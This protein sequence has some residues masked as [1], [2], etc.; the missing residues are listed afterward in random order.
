MTRIFALAIVIVCTMTLSGFVIP[1]NQGIQPLEVVYSGVIGDTA[2]L[3]GL[4]DSLANNTSFTDFNGTVI[5]AQQVSTASYTLLQSINAGAA[6]PG[7]GTRARPFEGRFISGNRLNTISMGNQW[8]TGT[9]SFGLFN[10]VRG[11]AEFINITTSGAFLAEN[12]AAVGSLIGSVIGGDVRIVTTHTIMNITTDAGIAGGVIGA[13]EL[14]NVTIL[15]NTVANITVTGGTHAGAIIG[16]VG[17]V[18]A[19][20]VNIRH[21][22]GAV[23][24]GVLARYHAVN[25]AAS[26][27]V[28]E[29]AMH[30][31]FV[32]G[33]I[34]NGSEVGITGMGH[35]TN[36]TAPTALF[37]PIAGI[38]QW[39][40]VTLAGQI[41]AGSIFNAMNIAV[42]LPPNLVTPFG[43]PFHTGPGTLSWVNVSTGARNIT[44]N[45]IGLGSILPYFN[46]RLP[47]DIQV[48]AN[49][50]RLVHNFANLNTAFIEMRNPSPS[51]L[52][53]YRDLWALETGVS[54]NGTVI[55]RLS[56]N[57]YVRRVL[58]IGLN[59]L[60]AT[61]SAHDLI[62]FDVDGY[63]LVNLHNHFNVLPHPFSGRE[64]FLFEVRTAAGGKVEEVPV[65]ISNVANATVNMRAGEFTI[66]VFIFVPD[67][68]GLHVGNTPIEDYYLFATGTFTMTLYNS[69]GQSFTPGDR[70][71]G[72]GEPGNGPSQLWMAIVFP[73]LGIA[74]VA[75]VGVGIF[76]LRRKKN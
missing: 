50:D 70:P 62:I 38:P 63:R 36:P 61:I 55:Y 56:Q 22:T 12:A 1:E 17:T 9:G 66:I 3:R 76:M 54:N 23:A 41:A 48:M 44:L 40:M 42:S 6:F 11:Q 57:V 43:L 49:E 30:R 68:Q 65:T 18:G 67:D 26:E 60:R 31:G 14:G 28:S 75:G 15:D 53:E 8:P 19:S 58:N 73:L 33:G 74:I 4:A 16:K 59:L 72:G 46:L 64:Q 34:S 32:T 47:T 35:A 27:A 2:S 39:T 13:V 45:D 71:G 5:P 29:S 37:Q 52:G 24:T 20:H 51:F 25:L 7:I 69:G 21:V 10:Y